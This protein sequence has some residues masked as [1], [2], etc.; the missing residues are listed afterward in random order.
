[1]GDARVTP[2]NPAMIRAVGAMPVPGQPGALEVNEEEVSEF[3][4][5][6][7]LA[8]LPGQPDWKDGT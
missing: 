3:L 1:M 6:A 4:F 7:A 2:N 5:C 8:F